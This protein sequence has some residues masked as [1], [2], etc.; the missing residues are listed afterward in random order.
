MSARM[1]CFIIA[2]HSP[3]GHTYF[4]LSLLL[5]TTRRTDHHRNASKFLF[6]SFRNLF[7]DSLLCIP[8]V[9][10]WWSKTRKKNPNIINRKKNKKKNTT[11]SMHR[12]HDQC[13]WRRHTVLANERVSEK[14][15]QHDSGR[16]HRS[17]RVSDLLQISNDLLDVVRE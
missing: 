4:S 12:P 9:M 15:R 7:I 10:A 17:Q 5:S 13:E 2:R 16:A 8:C 1:A 11:H 14:Q 3:T 6:L